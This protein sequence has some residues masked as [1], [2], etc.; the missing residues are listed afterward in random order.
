MGL[1]QSCNFEER[2]CAYGRPARLNVFEKRERAFGKTAL[3]THP[4]KTKKKTRAIRRRA[5]ALFQSEIRTHHH[6]RWENANQS[7]ARGFLVLI[8]A[9]TLWLFCRML[10][11]ARRALRVGH[12][13][14]SFNVIRQAI[15]PRRP[16]GGGRVRRR[17]KRSEA[18]QN[19]Q[20]SK[21]TT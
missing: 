21:Q 5:R 6:R 18:R 2:R 10:T 17:L 16:I 19:G 14:Q 9:Y 4:P 8:V 7:W 13:R 11:L 1:F 3:Q 15:Q 12:F 20:K